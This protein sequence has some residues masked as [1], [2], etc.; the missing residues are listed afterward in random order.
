MFHWRKQKLKDYKT[1]MLLFGFIRAIVIISP[2]TGEVLDI[3]TYKITL[4]QIPSMAFVVEVH[5]TEHL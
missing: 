4:T 1:G 5:F 2:L 3:H